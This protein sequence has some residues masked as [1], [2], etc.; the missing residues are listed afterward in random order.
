MTYYS[1]NNSNVVLHCTSGGAV[2]KE[3]S[4]TSATSC[5]D[6]Q[7]QITAE[8]IKEKVCYSQNMLSVNRDI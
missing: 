5:Y 7:E 6:C 4:P 2:R 1:S 3:N 8:H